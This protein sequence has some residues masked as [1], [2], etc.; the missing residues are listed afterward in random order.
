VWRLHDAGWRIRYDPAIGVEHGEPRSWRR[1]LVRRMRY[2][3]S[4]A[5]LAR[6]HPGRLAP[7]IARPAPTLTAIL[8][9]ARRPGLAAASAAVQ[10]ILLDGRVHRLGLPQHMS[11][12]WSV[13]TAGW[14]L[15]GVG[16][17]SAVLALPVCWSSGSPRAGRDG[18]RPRSW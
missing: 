12:R 6:R 2:G 14:T 3:T 4:A 16:H 7:V 18:A 13:E 9:L 15:V 10:A 8:V 1:L 5:P 11:L 17:A